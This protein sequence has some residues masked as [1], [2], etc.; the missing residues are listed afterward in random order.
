M[1]TYVTTNP[2]KVR[3]AESYLRDGSIKRLE[4]DYTEIQSHELAPIAAHGAREAYRYAGEPVLV[5]DAGLFIEEIDGFPGPYSSYVEDTLGVE[6]VH[7]VATGLEDQRA[8]FRC[9]LAYC[10]GDEF[11]ASPDPI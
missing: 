9:V 7:R 5:D 4:Y 3:E 2:G 6:G 11:D 10:D 1:L 8:S